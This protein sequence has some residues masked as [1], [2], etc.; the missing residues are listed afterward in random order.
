MS[1]PFIQVSKVVFSAIEMC[2][3]T[4]TLLFLLGYR[5]LPT[6]LSVIGQHNK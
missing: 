5:L 4:V 3:C 2:T 6:V 1:L